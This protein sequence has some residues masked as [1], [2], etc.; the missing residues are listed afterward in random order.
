MESRVRYKQNFRTNLQNDGKVQLIGI[1]NLLSSFQLCMIKSEQHMSN[2]YWL[3]SFNKSFIKSLNSGK[4]EAVCPFAS[5]DSLGTFSLT[6]Q[7]FHFLV[8]D[9]SPAFLAMHS[10]HL[11]H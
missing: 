6:F 8:E 11:C 7:T 4:R 2:V 3:Y 9:F 1:L 10:S 5:F